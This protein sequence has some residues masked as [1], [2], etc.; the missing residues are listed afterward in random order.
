M[1]LSGWPPAPPSTQGQGRRWP[2]FRGT[3]A[4]PAGARELVPAG[5]SAP[6]RSQGWCL[7]LSSFS[8]LPLE[9][10]SGFRHKK[11]FSS[12]TDHLQS[13]PL[14]DFVLLLSGD[15]VPRMGEATKG[16]CRAGSNGAV[17]GSRPDPLAIHCLS[18]VSTRLL[19]SQHNYVM[20]QLCH[21]PVS[22]R[23]SFTRLRKLMIAG[24]ACN[25][26]R[27]VNDEGLH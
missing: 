8:H 14:G 19:R 17:G 15:A 18:Q 20:Y 5:G 4:F 24:N 1:G 7:V 23:D 6:G 16:K 12:S 9:A 25:D 10:A 13:A 22:P 11:G 3:F 2:G 27:N 21:M 26:V